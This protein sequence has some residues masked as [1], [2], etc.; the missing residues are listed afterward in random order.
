[1]AS[2]SASALSVNRTSYRNS[3]L[4]NSTFVAHV[5]SRLD[6][7]SGP[8][9]L[10]P[11]C[12]CFLRKIQLSCIYFCVSFPAV[13]F[14]QRLG[15]A[16]GIT[17]LSTFMDYCAIHLYFISATTPRPCVESLPPLLPQKALTEDR[18]ARRVVRKVWRVL[19]RPASFR[20]RFRKFFTK[21]THV[22]ALHGITVPSTIN[23]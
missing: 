20:K 8:E 23:L 10:S 4:G 3:L 2:T 13:S 6:A 16:Q 9:R 5:F 12:D 18:D 7:R 21:S 11:S 15:E 1:M 17:V 19:G 22:S 14:A